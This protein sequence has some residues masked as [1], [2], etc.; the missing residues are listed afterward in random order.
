MI[1]LLGLLAGIVLG[2]FLQP[3]IPQGL[4]PYLPIAIVAAMDALFGA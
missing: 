2:L 3:T 1:P 4:Q